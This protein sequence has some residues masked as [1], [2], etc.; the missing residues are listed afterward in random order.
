MKICERC[1]NKYERNENEIVVYPNLC[2]DCEI[3]I[4]KTLMEE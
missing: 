2:K 1:G 3:K 4:T